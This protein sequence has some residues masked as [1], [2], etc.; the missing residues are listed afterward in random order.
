M[1]VKEFRDFLYKKNFNKVALYE[2]LK[3]N[4]NYNQAD[5]IIRNTRTHPLT[6]K[7]VYGQLLPKKYSDLKKQK[8]LYVKNNELSNEISWTIRPILDNAEKIELF[9]KYR[10]RFETNFL[11]GNYSICRDVLKD[12]EEKICVSLWSIENRLILDEYEKGVEEN[13]NTRNKYQQTEYDAFVIVLTD[14]FSRKAEKK[15]SIF[16]FTDFL[17]KWEE[18]QMGQESLP[19]A[20]REYI[21]FKTAYF[22]L[23]YYS[24]Y[25]D[26]LQ[27]ENTSSIIDRY[28][29]L[30]KI[31]QHVVAN[32]NDKVDFS[33]LEYF[34]E[35]LSHKI[36][37]ISLYQLRL[38]IS[39]NEVTQDYNTFVNKSILELLDNY[40]TGKYS[41]CIDQASDILNSAPSN[42]EIWEIYVKSLIFSNQNFIKPISKVCLLNFGLEQLYNLYSKNEKTNEAVIELLKFGYTIGSFKMSY[43][44]LNLISKSVILDSSINR[45]LVAELNSEFINPRIL[46]HLKDKKNIINW[47]DNSFPNS[48]TVNFFKYFNNTLSSKEEISFTSEIPSQKRELYQARKLLLSEKYNDT[49]PLFEKII[50]TK[51]EPPIFEEVIFSLYTSYIKEQFYEKG[52]KLFVDSYLSNSHITIKIKSEELIETLLTD[53]FEKLQ[54]IEQLIE[55]PILFFINQRDSQETYWAFEEFLLANNIERPSQL[56]LKKELLDIPK[57]IFLLKNVC[58]TEVLFH[59]IYFDTPLEIEVERIK[60]FQQLIEIDESNKSE[61]SNEISNITQQTAIRTGIKQVE[62]SKIFVN[63]DKLKLTDTSFFK[64]GFSRYLELSNYVKKNEF[65]SLDE[66]SNIFYA[67]VDEKSDKQ[68]IASKIKFKGNPAFDTF[69]DLFWDIRDRIISSNEYG[70]DAY[71][72]TR[73]R[74]GTLLN[75][76]RSVFEKLNLVTSK[77]SESKYMPN[78]YWNNSNVG[79][80][81]TQGIQEL[82]ADFS[83]SID[84]T[85]NLVKEE[86]IQIRTE[87]KNN[88]IEALFDYTYNEMDLFKIYQAYEDVDNYES[89]VEKVIKELWDKTEKNLA[90]IRSIISNDLKDRFVSHITELQ[91]GISNIVNKA[92]ISELFDN[93]AK[94]NTNIL[95]ELDTIVHWF[96]ISEGSFDTSFNIR[97]IIDTCVQITN[98]IY[99]VSRI[100]PNIDIACNFNVS[101]DTFIHFIDLIRILLDNIVRHSQ[102]HPDDLETQIHIHSDESNLFL[103]F[104]NNFSDTIDI[105]EL[106]QKLDKVKHNWSDRIDTIIRKEGGSGF[107]KINKILKYD[108]NREFSEFDYVISNQKIKISISM[109]KKGIV[110]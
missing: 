32:P 5:K 9:L 101:G 104:S 87:K 25:T 50:K 51:P 77:D 47:F 62:N 24:N 110:S 56:S 30:I 21:R 38:A 86:W 80:H 43:Q 10:K 6:K 99:P 78:E 34:I 88:E 83:R 94:S 41:T 108:L 73:I 81:V 20:I 105:D 84:A 15:L 19:D 29:M 40:T 33:E 75:Q 27:L 71:L 65:K 57:Y 55:L 46:P 49:I 52:I 31:F 17:N 14:I 70:L 28:N 12:V 1:T 74:H 54:S 95:Q 67:F 8:L 85:S 106:N 79:E 35:K 63:V 92:E 97:M 93:I 76:I 36:N 98:N 22:S 107:K 53:N 26:L 102:L 37:D 4:V 42:F 72:S 59:S 2:H 69:K 7:L 96:R 13:W 45:E 16:R 18:N 44:V 48:I 23:N 109:D 60:I 61:Y 103:E 11:K 68:D 39:Q 90:S 66:T 91:K 100:T 64:E 89:F 58:S 3:A 82:L